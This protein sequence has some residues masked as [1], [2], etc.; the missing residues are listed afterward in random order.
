M[1]RQRFE[2][3]CFQE[4]NTI[5]KGWLSWKVLHRQGE[6]PYGTEVV[7][8]NQTDA[9]RRILTKATETRWLWYKVY[10]SVLRQ[11]LLTVLQSHFQSC[12]WVNKSR[13]FYENIR[14]Y[15]NSFVMTSY[16]AN[17]D[18]MRDFGGDQT[19]YKVQ[20][21]IYRSLFA[22]TEDNAPNFSSFSL[23]VT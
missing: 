2:E 7:N 5:A 16:P 19:T 8:F 14:R 18:L 9:G 3:F 4:T 15:N 17:E 6:G 21:V 13:D 10:V 22:P 20:G 1:K 11:W 12:C 23:L